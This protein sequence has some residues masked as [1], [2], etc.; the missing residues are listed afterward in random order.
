M[1]DAQGQVH[2]YQARHN[3]LWYNNYIPLYSPNRVK[4]VPVNE[5]STLEA[6]AGS[7]VPTMVLKGCSFTGC[8][9]VTFSGPASNVNNESVITNVLERLTVDDIFN[10]W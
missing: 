8:S 5:V 1:H 3:C 4:D 2:I 6:G 7:S 9:I 10:D